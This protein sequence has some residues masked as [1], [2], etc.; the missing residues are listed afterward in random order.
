[1]IRHYKCPTC[2]Y[3]MAVWHL[4]LDTSSEKFCENCISRFTNK[5]SH[6]KGFV[7]NRAHRR[8]KN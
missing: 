4:S 5:I 6:V 8:F 2:G 3:D 7:L 1:M